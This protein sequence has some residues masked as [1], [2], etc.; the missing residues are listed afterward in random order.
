M[1]WQ[2]MFTRYGSPSKE[3]NERFYYFLLHPDGLTQDQVANYDKRAAE[4]IQYAQSL[5]DNLTEYRQALAARYNQ[6][7][8]AA[9]RYELKIERQP[10]SSYSKVKY[11]VTLNKIFEDGTT[12]TELN[13]RYEGK[14]R[15]EALARFEEL[16]KQRP[17]IEAI[18]DIEKRHWER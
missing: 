14:Q 13:E 1:S 18:M 15:R 2:D 10:P 4:Y 3:C 8:T 9:Y 5:I 16:K 17:G 7:A 6:L 11:F 12:V